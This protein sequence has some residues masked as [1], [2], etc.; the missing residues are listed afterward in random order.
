MKRVVLPGG[1]IMIL[2][3]T[4]PNPGLFKDIYSLYLNGL[5]PKIS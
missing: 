2:E 1:Q 4:T 5:L 3:L